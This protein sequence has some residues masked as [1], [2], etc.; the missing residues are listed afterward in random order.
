MCARNPYF[1]KLLTFIISVCFSKEI[2]LSPEKKNF[3]PY[4]FYIS[5]AETPVRGAETTVR[6]AETTVRGAET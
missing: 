4:I 5:G 1:L 2:F 6:G 3:L